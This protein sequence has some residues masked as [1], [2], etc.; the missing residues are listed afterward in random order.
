MRRKYM[1]QKRL[2]ASGRE[3]ASDRNGC[4]T[5]DYLS[6]AIVLIW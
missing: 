6:F 2:T 3:S 5:V 1:R 4:L